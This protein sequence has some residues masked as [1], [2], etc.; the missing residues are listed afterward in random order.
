MKRREGL[1]ILPVVKIIICLS[2]LAGTAICYAGCIS[3]AKKDL[4][5]GDG[6]AFTEKTLALYWSAKEPEVTV[7]E[8]VLKDG[9][10]CITITTDIMPA[11]QLYGSPPNRAGVFYLYSLYFLDSHLY[12]WNEFNLDIMG[13]GV[14]KVWKDYAKLELEPCIEMLDISGGRIQYAYSYLSGSQALA[15]LENRYRRIMVLSQWMLSCSQVPGFKNQKAFEDYWFPVLFPELVA[16]GARPP[17]WDIE[18]AVW[19]RTGNIRWNETYTEALL[20]PELKPLRNS[21][22]L[23]QDW[24]EAIGWIYLFYGW[25]QLAKSLEEVYLTK[26][27]SY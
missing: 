13:R 27:R 12:G 20:P 1:K 17:L 19:N 21:G 2:I 22:T 4:V 7:R 26:K 3:A 16:P 11:I 10:T 9:K 14:F 5:F 15:A 6:S 8:V 23:L 24:E 18:S 25:D